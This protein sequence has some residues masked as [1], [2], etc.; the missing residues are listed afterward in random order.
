VGT[1]KPFARETRSD[2]YMNY[3]SVWGNTISYHK[4]WQVQKDPIDIPNNC[5]F[6]KNM[7]GMIFKN[8][9]GCI[10]HYAYIIY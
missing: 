8:M 1:V 7:L 3:D 4:E 9:Y 2:R 10:C 5:S 6:V